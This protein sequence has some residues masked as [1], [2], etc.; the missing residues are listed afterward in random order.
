MNR[1]AR[2]PNRYPK[3][4]KSDAA[5]RLHSIF[6]S[7]LVLCLSMVASAQS[8][9]ETPSFSTRENDARA[10]EKTT[11]RQIPLIVPQGTPIRVALSRRVRIWREG[12]PLT[13]QVADTVYAFDQPVIP[14]GSE[15]RGRGTRGGPVTKQRPVVGIAN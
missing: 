12:A 15:D 9:S 8:P 1:N 3:C 4:R 6:S 13:G 5:F 11:P 10:P 2:P 7:T 14:A